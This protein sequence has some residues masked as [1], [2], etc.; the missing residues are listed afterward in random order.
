MRSDKKK[1][2][3]WVRYLLIIMALLLVTGGVYAYMVY[4]SLSSA[5]ENM[6]NPSERNGSSKRTEKVSLKDK[7]PFS[8]LLL[9]VDEREGDRGRSDTMIVLTVNPILES[10]KMVSIPRDTRTEIIG[11]GNGCVCIA[12]GSE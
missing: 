3:T 5:V 7:T 11:R 1:K 4:H 9:G 10:V 2:R 6:H 8:A 12:Y